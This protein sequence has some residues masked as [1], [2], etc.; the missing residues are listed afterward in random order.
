MNPA[1]KS[2]ER[3]RTIWR[4]VRFLLRHEDAEGRAGELDEL[5]EEQKRVRGFRSAR[6]AYRVQFVLS[7]PGLI[8]NFISWEAAMLKNYLM[9]A[10]R[11]IVKNKGIS[12]INV[13]ACP[14]GWPVRSS[15]S[16]GL[17]AR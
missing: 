15:F 8:R 9:I 11:N 6:R 10:W 14:W 1:K 5:F 7:L 17:T 2:P 13:A 4:L 3:P 12:F 16:S